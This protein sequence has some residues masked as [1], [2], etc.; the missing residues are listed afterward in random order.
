MPFV[1]EPIQ[2]VVMSHMFLASALLFTL[3]VILGFIKPI[4]VGWFWAKCNRRK[5]LYRYGGISIVS[6][7]AYFA[8][9]VQLH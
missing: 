6:W 3:A 7:I 4:L 1:F 2:M 9:M 8:L 5:V